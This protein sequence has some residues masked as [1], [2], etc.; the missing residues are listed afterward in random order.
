M[1]M[2]FV[3]V[4][5]RPIYLLY[6]IWT[7]RRV[8]PIC[9]NK[10]AP[11]L[12]EWFEPKSRSLNSQNY[13]LA[14]PKPIYHVWFMFVCLGSRCMTSIGSTHPCRIF[15]FSTVQTGTMWC[16]LQFFVKAIYIK[17]WNCLHIYVLTYIHITPFP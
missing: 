13:F 15:V 11:E 10:S 7:G 5:I 6:S 14:Q 9:V 16:V 1:H 12:R 4:T 17:Y 8:R 3:R 2:L